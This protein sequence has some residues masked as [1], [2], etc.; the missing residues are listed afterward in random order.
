MNRTV[1][2]AAAA[3]LA[4]GGAL[5]AFAPS[6]LGPG[7]AAPDVAR[8][9]WTE[10]Q[11]PFPKDPWGRGRAFRC[12]PAECA[13]EVNLYLRAKLG[14]CN[15]VTGI[16]DDSDLDGMGDV[17]LVG[18][19]VAPLGD[20]RP[21]AIGWMKGR[22][23]AYAR[24]GGERDEAVLSV[25]FNDRCDMVVATIVLPRDRLAAVESN[26]IAFLNS[27]TVLHWTRITLGI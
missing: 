5:V 26:V 1:A 12:G 18:G 13:A 22:A 2:L 19:A 15:C 24:A 20:G 7:S 9:A 4:I 16:A 27:E 21:V 25:A 6:A 11:W 17:A 3:A 10:A 14:F 23:R 8:S